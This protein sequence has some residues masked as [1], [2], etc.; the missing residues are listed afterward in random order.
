MLNTE[1][2]PENWYHL[3]QKPAGLDGSSTHAVMNSGRDDLEILHETVKRHRILASPDELSGIQFPCL[4]S[5][6]QEALAATRIYMRSLYPLPRAFIV[7][8]NVRAT[9][10]FGSVGLMPVRA[11]K[12]ELLHHSYG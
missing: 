4:P 10:P 9:F 11:A 12:E 6:V 1:E 5:S 2:R 3:V 8:T 7:V